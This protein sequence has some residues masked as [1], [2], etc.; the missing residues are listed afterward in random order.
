MRRSTPT[1]WLGRESSLA[2]RAW[3]TMVGIWRA[4]SLGHGPAVFKSLCCVGAIGWLA[5]PAVACANGSVYVANQL[6]GNVSQYA[7]GSGGL[8]S[9]MTPATVPAGSDPRAIA[10]SPSGKSAYVTNF[11]AGG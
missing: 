11:N 2:V 6:S 3:R 4:R 8:L 10:L 7:I 1:C 5:L 9:P